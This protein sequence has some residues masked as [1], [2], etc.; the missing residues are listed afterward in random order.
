MKVVF[1]VLSFL[2]VLVLIRLFAVKMQEYLR[3]R[4]FHKKQEEKRQQMESV[5]T[6]DH[7]TTNTDKVILTG[8]I[9]NEKQNLDSKYIGN[10]YRA[11]NGRFVSKKQLTNV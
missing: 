1:L 3:G 5:V 11:K 4:N 8:S 9:N 7:N 2:V 6:D 10:V